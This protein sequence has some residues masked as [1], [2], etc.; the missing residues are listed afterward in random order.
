MLFCETGVSFAI[1][2]IFARELMKKTQV[3]FCLMSKTGTSLIL[4]TKL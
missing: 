2:I 3:Q 1:I 4:L